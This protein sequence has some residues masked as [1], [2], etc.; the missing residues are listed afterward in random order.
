MKQMKGLD[1]AFVAFERTHSPLHVASVAIYDP[2]TAPG[3]KV[4]YKD[5]LKFIQSRIRLAPSMRRRMVK[6]PFG[7]DYPYWVEDPHFDLEYHVRR[8]ALPKPHDWQ[9]LCNLTASLFA[10]P[11]DLE[12]PPWEVTIV[13]GVDNID[14]VPKGSYAAISKV[15]HAAI[16][17]L[18]GV[19]LMQATHTLQPDTEPPGGKDTWKP[20]RMPSSLG[21]FMRGYVRAFTIPIRQARA[22]VETA[23]GAIKLAGGAIRGDLKLKGMLKTP[24]TRFN[25]TITP[26]RVVVG[27]SF[28]LK[29]IK[30]MRTIVEGATINDVMLSIV[31]GAMRA[32]LLDK[33]ELPDDSV[34]AMA[35]ISV[36]TDDEKEDMGNQ[37]TAMRAPLGTQIEDAV[38]RLAFVTS[39]TQNSKAVTKALGARHMT[40]ISQNNPALYLGLASRL[41]TQFHLA[42]RIKPVFNTIVTNVPG[43]GMPLYSAGAKMLKLYGMVCI[44]DGVG[45]GHVVQSYCDE[46]TIMAAACRKAMPDPDFYAECMR[47]SFNAH[48][49]AIPKLKVAAE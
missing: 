12:R 10:R 40:D 13:E 36:R 1:A 46:I 44:V 31:G 42:N 49:A 16:D 17:G 39:E 48:K 9:E 28:P 18:A 38:E 25:W 41:F 11:L 19:E 3:G 22:V 6:P 43:P 37:L 8:A 47:E 30:A 2:S 35:P 21:L 4:E 23:P 14:G 29:K 45:L 27:E 5:I 33:D 7:I 34:V 20:E 24:R 15:H 26:H 32:Y